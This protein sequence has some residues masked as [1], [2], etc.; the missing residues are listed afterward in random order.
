MPRRNIRFR[1]RTYRVQKEIH[2][3]GRE[4]CLVKRLSSGPRERYQ[5]I[6]PVAEE[7]RAIT[8]LPKASTS[9]QR[10]RVVQELARRNA[11]NFPKVMEIDWRGGSFKVLQDW[12]RGHDLASK[13]RHAEEHPERWPGPLECFQIYRNLAHGLIQL[14]RETGMIHGDI[15]PGNLVMDR[16]R[17][18]IVDFGNAWFFEQA[19]HRTEGEGISGAYA[20]PEQH[21]GNS[22]ITFRSDFFSA[23]VIAYQL[24]TRQLPYDGVGGKAG[25]PEYGDAFVNKLVPPSQ[26]N[27]QHELLPGDFWQSIDQIVLKNLSLNPNERSGRDEWL[28][29]LDAIN[30]RLKLQP[31]LGAVR[32]GLLGIFDW[33][34]G[35]FRRRSSQ[36]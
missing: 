8:I 19:A 10:L 29:T 15:K 5:A 26:F 20:S 36:N 21:R 18:F 14:H 28:Q 17:V 13:I 1:G 12:V 27:S 34:S 11:T 22:P 16:T 24:L 9:L 7:F 6:D 4:Y 25:R 2:L 23:S 30:A 31:Q 32:K 3:G 33:L 35:R